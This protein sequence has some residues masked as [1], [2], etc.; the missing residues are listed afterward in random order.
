MSVLDSRSETLFLALTEFRQLFVGSGVRH[1]VEPFQLVLGG[2]IECK[3]ALCLSAHFAHSFADDRPSFCNCK[4]RGRI[5][6]KRVVQWL[7]CAS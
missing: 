6:T 2:R 7:R 4:R 3:T 1:R 5:E